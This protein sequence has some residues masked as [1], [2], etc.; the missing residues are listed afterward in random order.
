MGSSVEGGALSAAAQRDAELS[1]T[2]KVPRKR[3]KPKKR[4]LRMVFM[5][6]LHSR[7]FAQ[8]GGEG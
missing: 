7:P 2:I 3:T 4:A 1:K 6:G 8:P 5:L